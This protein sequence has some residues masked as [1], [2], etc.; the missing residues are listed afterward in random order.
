MTLRR[1]LL[2][3]LVAAPLGL[4]GCKEA[5]GKPKAE[6]ESG[7]PEQ[8]LDFNVLYKQNCAACHGESGKNGAAISLA[9]P[10]YLATAGAPNIQR[11][12]ASGVPGTM[13]PAF[14]KA[15]GG[16][17]TD[18]QIAT[19][20]QGMMTNWGNPGSLGGLA[21]PSYTATSHGDAAQGQ[22]AFT[23]YCAR[24]HGADGSGST[25]A[26]RRRIGSLIDPAYLALV[27][28]QGLRSFIIA[29]QPDAGMPDWR[30]DLNGPSLHPMSEQ[31]LA[32]TVAYLEA[33]RIAA[34][35]QP[36]QH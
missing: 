6:V 31:D 9:N 23:T 30:S 11:I 8:V 33:H 18:Q 20:A 17:L 24:C 2:L 28:E 25:D 26:N 10:I 19:L 4:G 7:R 27:S 5:P 32:D 35:G 13:M 12:T 1:I 21:P 3:L 16:P 15:A 14:G 22:K 34:P 36:Y 29:G